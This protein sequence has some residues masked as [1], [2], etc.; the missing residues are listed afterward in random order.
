MKSR[1]NLVS[2]ILNC[3]NG[4]KYLGEALSSIK[5]QTYKNWELIFWDNKSTDN[6][7]KILRTFKIKKLKYFL[8]K[9]H[10]SLYA[11]RNL[12]IKKATGEYIG[13]IDADDLWEKNKL[14]KQIS[15][16]TDKETIVV[17]GNSWLKNEKKNK[18]KKFINYKVRGGY[19]Y[20]DLVERYNV[21][22]VTSLI[23]KSLL[24]K[25]KITFNGKYDIIGD[26]DFFLRLSKQYK[27]Q[28][29][30]EPI[31]TYR[32]HYQ[33]LSFLKKNKQIKEFF[34]W[35]KK[36]QYQLTKADY[37]KIKNKVRNL[38]FI[39]IKLTKSFPHSFFYFLKFIKSVLNLKNIIILLTPSPILKR[40][41]WF[42]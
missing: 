41:M 32:I 24:K 37:L 25:S 17:Y 1:K 13:F 27:F 33:N 6:S 39:N 7:A 19:I 3:Y 26:Y 11:A 4:E 16:F 12:A 20:K 30:N 28:F 22:I 8:S 42:A 15:L 36:N 18:K 38:E 23:K 10:T 21:G 14:K 9:K 2:I 40:F 35:I 34:Y 5:G 29:I 31:A